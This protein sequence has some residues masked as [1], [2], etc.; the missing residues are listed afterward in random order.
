M[1]CLLKPLPA[2]TTLRKKKDG[3]TFVGDGLFVLDGIR[4]KKGA[5]LAILDGAVDFTLTAK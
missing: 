4:L 5:D 3:D 2:G 1:K